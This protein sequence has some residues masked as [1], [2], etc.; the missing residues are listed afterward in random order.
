M[1]LEFI[2]EVCDLG[3]VFNGEPGT[4]DRHEREEDLLCWG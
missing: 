4:L 3:E 2:S 1:W